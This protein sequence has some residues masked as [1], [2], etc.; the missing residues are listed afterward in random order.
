VD[1]PGR[2][3]T[4]CRIRFTDC[5]NSR[6]ARA[7]AP[8]RGN[9]EIRHERLELVTG[10]RRGRRTAARRRTVGTERERVKN[11]DMT[12]QAASMRGCGGQGDL[13]MDQI[14]TV[15]AEHQP[16]APEGMTPLVQRV[17]NLQPRRDR[18][19]IRSG[20]RVSVVEIAQVDWVEAEGNYVRLHVGDESHLIRA[21]MHAVEQRLGTVFIR[22][23][24]SRI[25]NAERIQ[26]L[27]VAPN[28]EY[29]TV[30]RTGRTLGVSRLYRA[31]VQDRLRR[32]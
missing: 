3:A 22:I 21:T 19:V 24:R 7:F 13:A 9:C 2:P 20:V 5:V 16:M 14:R 10:V 15:S 11:L 4:V 29:E 8:N 31:R 30:L 17:S 26:E 12:R 28:G 1:W 25:V 6:L 18:L 27:R 23:H 32:T